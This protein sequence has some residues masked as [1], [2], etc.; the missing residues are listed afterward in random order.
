[1]VRDFALLSGDH[2][3]IHL[4]LDYAAQSLFKRPIV[5]GILVA[6][7]ISHLLAGE[8]PGP[9]SI[10]VHQSLDFKRPVF[11]NEMITCSVEV[12]KV[13]SERSLIYLNTECSNE[14]G[15]VV[16]FGNAIIKKI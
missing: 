2:N 3:P 4:D 8:L 15:E 12:M 6:S 9:G 1:M 16:I 14:R 5:H 11:W 13:E 10:Y 7:Q